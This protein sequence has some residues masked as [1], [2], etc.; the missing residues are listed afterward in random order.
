[1]IDHLRGTNEMTDELL[2]LALHV[3]GK[4]CLVAG[5]GPEAEQRARRLLSGGARVVVIATAPSAAL[6]ALADQGALTLHERAVDDTDLDG[7]WFAVL[8]D[9]DEA[10]ARRLGGA[11]EA[12]RVWFCA[13]DQPAYGSASHLAEA[14]AGPLTLGISTAGRVPALARRLREELTRLFDEAG[15][16]EFVECLAELR[17]KLPSAARRDTLSKL[18]SGLRFAGRLELPE[19]PAPSSTEPLT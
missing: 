15:F 4:S 12:R 16:A 8:T 11:A 9:R 10:L 19:L 13:V 3:K 7:V 14:H 2:P 6:R 1:M 17:A 18:L 5:S